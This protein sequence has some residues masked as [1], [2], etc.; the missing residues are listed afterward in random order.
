M[1]RPTTRAQLA[2]YCLRALGAPVM[3]INIDE[4]QLEDRIDEA[5]QF[6]QEY[7]SDA[8]VRSFIKHQVTQEEIDDNKISVPDA[9]LSVTRVLSFQDTNAASMFSTKYQMHL[10]DFYGLRNPG[11][12][13]NYEMTSQYLSLVEDIISGHG[14]QLSYVRHANLIEFHATLSDYLVEDDWIVIEC[15]QTVNPTQYA[16][17]YNDMALKELC[18]LL[19]KKQWGQNLSK[20]EGMQLPGGVTINGRQIYDDAVNDLKELKEKFDSLYSMPP[21]FFIG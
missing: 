20:F 18:T 21:D 11:G 1:A 8:M 15:Y 14:V 7:H 9:V 12:L 17:V 5:I 10:N 6:W 19:I 3:E 16:D 13:V 4:D 2:D